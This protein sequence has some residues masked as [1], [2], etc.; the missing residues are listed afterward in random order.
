MK[1]TENTATVEADIITSSTT[2]TTSPKTPPRTIWVPNPLI[3]QHTQGETIS[4]LCT[5]GTFRTFARSPCHE[6]VMQG[7]CDHWSCQFRSNDELNRQMTS[8]TIIKDKA[9][10]FCTS[11][12]A[13]TYPPSPSSDYYDFEI[14]MDDTGGDIH[15]STATAY[16]TQTS[17]YSGRNS[18]SSTMESSS[19]LLPKSLQNSSVGTCNAHSVLLPF[20][21]DEA[22]PLYELLVQKKRLKMLLKEYNLHFNAKHGRM[23]NKLEKEPLRHLY[24]IHNLF[25]RRISIL[26]KVEVVGGERRRF[27]VA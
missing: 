26:E 2:K 17:M 16:T 27:Y 23:P 25:K 8:C 10:S 18:T 4:P 22:I 1:F 20:V 14:S 7:S 15:T 21:P 24:E 11:T 13:R 5:D 3:S 19:Q 9:G 12:C 6:F